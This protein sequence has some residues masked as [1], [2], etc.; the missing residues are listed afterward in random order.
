GGMWCKNGGWEEVVVVPWGWGLFR[1]VDTPGSGIGK[2]S[3]SL[4]GPSF[5]PPMKAETGWTERSMGN[6]CN[7]EPPIKEN[8][9]CHAT[10]AIGL[11]TGFKNSSNS[12]WIFGRRVLAAYCSLPMSF[13]GTITSESTLQKGALISAAAFPWTR[14][15]P[16]K[17]FSFAT[18]RQG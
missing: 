16:R 4:G 18:T 14:S 9:F 5:P 13:V 8:A 3:L 11:C 6:F 17:G 2:N 10:F 12:A 15:D 1:V 7:S